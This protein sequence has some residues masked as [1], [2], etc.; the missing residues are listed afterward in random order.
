[1]GLVMMLT[2]AMPVTMLAC[3]RKCPAVV[4]PGF[5]ARQTMADREKQKEQ[6]QAA[7]TLAYDLFQ[8]IDKFRIDPWIACIRMR[9]EQLP[10]TV[11]DR[12]QDCCRRC[13][14][15]GE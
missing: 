4:Y 8:R 5:Q 2:F 14:I 9:L 7:C 3:E 12:L 10:Y 1:M 6:A 15:K 11:R 13:R